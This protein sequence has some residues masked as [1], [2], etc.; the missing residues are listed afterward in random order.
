MG[1]AYGKSALSA[2]ISMPNLD[3]YL[4]KIQDAG[5]DIDDACISAVNSALPIVEKAMKDGAARH[6]K[7]VG[8]YGTD[9]VYNAI[10]ITPAHTAGNYIYGTV[11]IDLDKH[12][13]AFNGVYQEYGDG[14]SP[15]FPDPF[16]RPSTE[17]ENK[18]KILAAERAELRKRGIPID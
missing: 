8:K 1:N 4:K 5:N 10:E 12:P 11:G 3:S 9:A 2:T 17:G 18:K 7:G 14:H 6:R 16:V 15:Q 13:E